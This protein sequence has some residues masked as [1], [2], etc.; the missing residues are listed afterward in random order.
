MSSNEFGRWLQ[1]QLDRR[2]WKPADFAR[3]AR[4]SSG[5]VSNWLSGARRPNPASVD[6]I[7]DALVIDVDEVL[8]RAGHRPALPRDELEAVHAR[9]DPRL[10]RVQW[11]EFR[12]G[13]VE[14]ML[15]QFIQDDCLRQAASSAATSSPELP[16]SG[17][18]RP[19]SGT[20]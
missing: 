12:Y 14:S 17:G 8:T 7:A 18:A 19:A 2:E 10:R 16:A 6:K 11:S 20:K 5:L 1:H 4:V 9:L 13:L 3:K 15:D